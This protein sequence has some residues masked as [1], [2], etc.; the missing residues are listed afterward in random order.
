[1]ATYLELSNAEGDAG[2]TNLRSKV[3]AAA[4]IKAQLIVAQA[5]AAT[6]KARDWAIGALQLPSSVV[7]P[8]F[9]F[10]LADNANLTV[11]QLQNASDA[12]VQTAVNKA[13][14]QLFAL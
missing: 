9:F 1:M 3:K 8:L 5:G 11:A 6:S 10:V 12:A 13:V 14:D 7:L 2:F 4:T